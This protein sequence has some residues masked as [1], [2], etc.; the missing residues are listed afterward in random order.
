M[1]FLQHSPCSVRRH[2]LHIREARGEAQHSKKE[3]CVPYMVKRGEIYY[4][5]LSPGVGSEQKGLRPVLVV[6]NDVGN[7]YSPTVIV[8]AI[9]SRT[10]KSRLPT[11]IGL[12]ACEYGLARDSVV[13]AEQI[14]KKTPLLFSRGVECYFRDARNCSRFA[15][16][17]FSRSSSVSGSAMK[18]FS[19]SSGA[20]MG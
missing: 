13:L 8:T 4:A 19:S 3:G 17:I 10:G 20:H 18:R 2:N 5:D 16:R 14:R 7:R 15:C 6:Q 1:S 12:Q 9:T 11:H